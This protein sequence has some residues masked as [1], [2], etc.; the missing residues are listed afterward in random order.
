MELSDLLD[1]ARD[2]LRRIE[3]CRE[4]ADAAA[5]ARLL[6]AASEAGNAD[7]LESAR[8]AF[9]DLPDELLAEIFNGWKPAGPR[10][11]RA[12]LLATLELACIQRVLS[13]EVTG[14]TIVPS[15][16]WVLR[17]GAAPVRIEIQEGARLAQV[18][19]ALAW[20]E[21]TLQSFLKNQLWKCATD[22]LGA[23]VIAK[24]YQGADLRNG[25]VDLPADQ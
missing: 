3:T 24:L 15:H 5:V 21:V 19:S 23:E 10:P 8:E 14:R 22:P 20:L 9:Y 16:Q 25:T 7:A 11:P 13:I 12:D 4:N 17:D 6:V 1:E 18:L 2:L